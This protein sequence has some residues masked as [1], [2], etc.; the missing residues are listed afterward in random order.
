M[1]EEEEEGTF[2]QGDG[3]MMAKAMRQ[4]SFGSTGSPAP[5]VEVE[6]AADDGEFV[7]EE[8]EEGLFT[9]GDGLMAAKARMPRAGLSPP[10]KS[11]P[12]APL[13]S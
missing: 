7:P 8:E 11:T 13:A 1:P 2:T 9:Q 5:Q 4:R 12:T 3:L 10:S 6:P